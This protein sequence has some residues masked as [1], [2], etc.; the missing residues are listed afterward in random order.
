M[1]EYTAAHYQQDVVEELANQHRVF[2][3]GPG[4]E[5]YSQNDTI[6]DVIAKSPFDRPDIIC[7]GHAWLEDNPAK[8]IEIHP[9][10]DLSSYNHPKVMILNKE[11]TNLERKLA[12]IKENK[13]SLVFSHLKNINLVVKDYYAKFVFWPFAANHKKFFDYRL[14]KIYD[15]T[16]TGILR[17]PH[18][19]DMQSDFRVRVQKQLFYCVGDLKI[20]KRIQHMKLR[21]YWQARP[22][23]KWANRMNPYISK[24]VDLSV[25]EYAK[26]LNRSRICLNSL[27]PMDLIS[28]RYFESMATRCLVLCQESH[29]YEGLFEVDKHCIT[30]KDD[31][32]DFRQKLDYCLNETDA[33]SDVIENAYQ[34]VLAHHTWKKRIEQFS[35]NILAQV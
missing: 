18:F 12:Y 27:S 16:F 5:S 23:S 19:P 33:I 21:L 8:P 26:L 34:H 14:P 2:L 22:V 4:F 10:L 7:I 15:L 25:S 11:Y 20:Q 13:I 1:S 28:P 31:L 3:Y 35:E 24:V 32:S 17:N 30:I 29:L 6:R 9:H